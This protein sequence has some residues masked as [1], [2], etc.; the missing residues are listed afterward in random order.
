MKENKK[1]DRCG[2]VLWFVIGSVLIVVGFVIIP[3]L[4]KI[5]GNKAYKKSLYME[6]IDFDDMGPEIVPFNDETEGEE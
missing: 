6:D 2:K 3:P 4:I 5:Y 1:K